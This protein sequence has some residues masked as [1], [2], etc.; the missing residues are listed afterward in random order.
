[1]TDRREF[2]LNFKKQVISEYINGLCSIAQLCRKYN[3]NQSVLYRWKLQFQQGKLDNASNQHAALED[4]IASL[5]RLV[6][7]LTLENE[8]LKKVLDTTNQSRRREP[9]S[10]STGDIFPSRRDVK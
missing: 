3:I 4:R 5:E 8:F 2:T 1:M 10:N 9:Q 6:G 7:K